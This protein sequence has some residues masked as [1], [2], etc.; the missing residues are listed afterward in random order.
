MKT[1]A[2]WLTH[3]ARRWVS[4]AAF[5]A[6]LLSLG[7]ISLQFAGVLPLRIGFIR[8]SA[9]NLTRP[10]VIA[11]VSSAALVIVNPHTRRWRWIGWAS[12]AV[13]QFVGLVSLSRSLGPSWL[14][15]DAALLELNVI[16]ALGGD[17]FLGAYSQY[18]WHHPGPLFSYWLAAFYAVGGK[19]AAAMSAG[20][21]LL[22]LVCLQSILASVSRLRPRFLTLC[23]SAMLVLLML[24]TPSLLTSYWNPHVILY[25]VVAL[26][27]AS[28]SAVRRPARGLVSSILFGS[29]AAQT[30]VSTVPVAAAL[31]VLAAMHVIRGERD[32]L[33]WLNRG[34][35]IVLL[36]W[37]LP[38]SEQV[39]QDD[40]NMSKL[41]AFF[42]ASGQVPQPV[43][44]AA[45]VWGAQV[46][47]V[48]RPEL[49]VPL[50]V[51]VRASS[52]V[53]VLG[54]VLLT[55]LLPLVAWREYRRRLVFSSAVAGSTFLAAG[56]GWWSISRIDGP[57]ADHQV[58]WLVAVGVVGLAVCAASG[59]SSHLSSRA[60]RPVV[61]ALPVVLLG[62]ASVYG[63]M[64]LL[65]GPHWQVDA[66]GR[67]GAVLESQV[68]D[69]LRSRGLS[70]PRIELT[71]DTWEVGVGLILRRVRAGEAV[72]IGESALGLLGRRFASI[73]NDDVAL[74]LVKT[75]EAMALLER[76]GSFRAAESGDLVVI[77]TVSSTDTTR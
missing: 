45:N 44:E 73:G 14:V 48:I 66:P 65:A 7:V 50:G 76:P 69:A 56:V 54:G 17:Q 62:W 27:F 72:T 77:G 23:T 52:R 35:W 75:S 59:A 19:S 46:M 32:A 30:H 74:F 1:S 47:G 21:L 67:R 71:V 31:V 42:T 13:T 70:R 36:C 63:A 26:L 58:L 39:S 6:C 20:A 49:T 10:I 37:W 22:N 53:W 2:P 38:L 33:R 60:L 24:R 51:P 8:I 55:V 11:L 68:N 3:D 5:V 16:A 15:G 28:A 43:S 64:E 41:L 40:G 9:A 57:I 18:G 34:A 61:R 12:F 29:F 25:P 4:R